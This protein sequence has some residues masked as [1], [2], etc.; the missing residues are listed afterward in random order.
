MLKAIHKISQQL[1]LGSHFMKIS[2]MEVKSVQT[3]SL[4]SLV[5]RVVR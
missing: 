4:Y 5:L 2:G 1:S 3:Q